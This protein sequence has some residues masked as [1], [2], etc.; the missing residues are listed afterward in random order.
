MC[1]YFCHLSDPHANGL[2]RGRGFCATKALDVECVSFYMM[3]HLVEKRASPPVDRFELCL[4]IV[5]ST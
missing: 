3:H 4:G 1:E 5:P 2:Q